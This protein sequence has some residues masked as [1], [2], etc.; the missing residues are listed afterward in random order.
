M[1]F[2]SSLFPVL[3]LCFELGN[4]LAPNFWNMV[5]VNQW[6]NFEFL[7]HWFKKVLYEQG[8]FLN[9]VIIRSSELK[10]VC[11]IQ[12]QSNNADE[13][14]ACRIL[15]E[16]QEF[17]Q[18]RSLV[19]IVDFMFLIL[20][21]RSGVLEAKKTPTKIFLPSDDMKTMQSRAGDSTAWKIC[22]YPPQRIAVGTLVQGTFQGILCARGDF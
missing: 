11:F 1:N 2:N 12:V 22:A 18:S 14:V 20:H 9:H 5:Q 16:L 15:A 7:V 21:E 4:Q 3:N 19:S 10:N 8:D 6:I 13:N 17:E